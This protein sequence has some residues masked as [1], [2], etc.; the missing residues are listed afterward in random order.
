MSENRT[1]I[2]SALSLDQSFVC[3]LIEDGLTPIGNAME[4]VRKAI[5]LPDKG[6]ARVAELIDGVVVVHQWLKQAVLLFLA[7]GR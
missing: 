7:A 6:E 4:A 1:S 5:D 2:S 3:G